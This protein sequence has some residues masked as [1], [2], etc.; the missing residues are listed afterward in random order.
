MGW[1]FVRGL[2]SLPASALQ[3]A[4]LICFYPPLLSWHFPASFAQDVS[5]LT[6]SLSFPSRA[7]VELAEL[8]PA[9]SLCT[10][11]GKK[12][13]FQSTWDYS[14]FKFA[15]FSQRKVSRLESLGDVDIVHASLRE[16]TSFW[17]VP[18]QRGHQL[19]WWRPDFCLVQSKDLIQHLLTHRA[20]F[21]PQSNS[22]T[23]C[24]KKQLFLKVGQLPQPKMSCTSGMKVLCYSSLFSIRQRENPGWAPYPQ[25]C[26]MHK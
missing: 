9:K 5:V 22:V 7:E 19:G 1:L 12:R 14:G 15:N 25:D 26:T 13:H 6:V 11:G 17:S 21:W 8:F 3:L 4:T 24:E 16:E 10:Q 23:G 20:V 2:I 18:Q